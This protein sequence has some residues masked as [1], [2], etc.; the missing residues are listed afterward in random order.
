[1]I[2]LFHKGEPRNRGARARTRVPTSRRNCLGLRRK[3]IDYSVDGPS[4][5]FHNT[6]PHILGCICSA[7]RHVFRRSGRSGLNRAYGNGE[8]EDDR[9][10]RFHGTK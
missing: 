8:G 9:K 4:C 7:L 3:R 2:R 6:V 10:E 5:A 1:M